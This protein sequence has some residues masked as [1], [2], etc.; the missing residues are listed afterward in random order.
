MFERLD[1]PYGVMAVTPELQSGE[2]FAEHYSLAFDIA[3]TIEVPTP[4]ELADIVRATVSEALGP[5]T[6]V[7]EVLAVSSLVAEA[8]NRG[9]RRPL[10]CNKKE[11]GQEER[12]LWPPFSFKSIKRQRALLRDQTR[13]FKEQT[14]CYRAQIEYLQEATLL[15]KD[16][17]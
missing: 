7:A 10:E 11:L 9:L 14:E 12:R 2:K 6:S 15:E 5:N 17:L 3:R 16:I 1:S 8:R 4:E 13:I